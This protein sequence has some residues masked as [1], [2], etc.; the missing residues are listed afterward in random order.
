MVLLY[1]SGKKRSKIA[2]EYDLL[3]SIL[4]NWIRRISFTGSAKECNNRSN[5]ILRQAA[6]CKC[7]E[8]TRSTY[9]YEKCAKLDE[10]DLE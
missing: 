10:S 2:R 6:M 9:Y 7:L 1:Y 4:S 8:I 5:D 3:P